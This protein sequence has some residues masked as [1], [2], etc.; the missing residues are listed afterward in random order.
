L[1]QAKEKCY[2]RSSRAIGVD[3][4]QSFTLPESVTEPAAASQQAASRCCDV[5][6]RF[7]SLIQSSIRIV[8]FKVLKTGPPKAKTLQEWFNRRWGGI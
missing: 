6:T 7:R 2:K 3:A 8:R 1:W 4:V 5:Q